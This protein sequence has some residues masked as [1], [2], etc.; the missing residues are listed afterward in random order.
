MQKLKK[1]TALLSALLLTSSL[2]TAC[3]NNASPY[4]DENNRNTATTHSTD[5]NTARATDVRKG[6]EMYAT[7]NR[8]TTDRTVTMG[9]SPR[10]DSTLESRVEA[11]PGVSNATVLVAG[12]FAFVL[13]DQI[14]TSH[15][16][17]TYGAGMILS[18][19]MRTRIAAT[20]QNANPAI[21]NVYFIVR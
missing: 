17:A 1:T 20:I 7:P 12:K 16:T 8:T 11:L 3:A 9:D 19:D 15:T 2:M 4:N 10:P 21:R 14:S 13:V 5:G 6:P 18:T